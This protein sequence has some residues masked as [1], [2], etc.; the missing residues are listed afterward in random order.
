MKNVKI[1]LFAIA[2]LLSFSVSKAQ[3]KTIGIG[4]L[5]VSLNYDIPL[6][7]KETG[8]SI[9]TIKFSIIESGED[10]GKF[11]TTTKF[12]LK[13]IEYY[14]GDSKKEAESHVN[15]GLIYFAPCL[16]F[17]V[18]RDSNNE[19]EVVLNEE[20]FETAI[21]KNDTI[22][23][24]YTVGEPYWNMSHSNSRYSKNPNETWFLY[25]TWDIYLKRMMFIST[26]G[27]KLYDNINGTEI[28]SRIIDW[29]VIKVTGD[30]AMLRER[31][32]S[33]N[34]GKRKQYAWV[35]WTDGEKFLINLYPEV[36]Y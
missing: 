5:Q 10:E 28:D 9:D 6:Y 35:R 26:E 22:H 11:I 33:L 20:S 31:E 25:E 15:D 21:I 24:L 12:S 8:V 4:R 1:L 36:Y 17:R 2:I 34:R 32:D 27:N 13:P 18:L 29:T 16:S 14:A 30:W 23:K 19:Y 3:N 7:N